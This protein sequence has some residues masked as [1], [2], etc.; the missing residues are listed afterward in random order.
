MDDGVAWG[1]EVSNA[2]PDNITVRRFRNDVSEKSFREYTKV[3]DY[4]L[5]CVLGGDIEFLNL[6]LGLMNCAS[7][8]PCYLCEIDQK[9]LKT[10]AKDMDAGSTRNS[11]RFE[12]QLENVLAH[13][14]LKK[15]KEASKDNGSVLR[16]KLLPV[17]FERVS[18]ASRT[19]HYPGY[20]EEAFRR[21]GCG[22]PKS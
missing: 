20:C 17:A 22:A 14:L 8:F 1:I 2:D 16:K 15:K 11:A 9:T 13:D 4:K 10:R 5:H 19:S 12:Q 7:T 3:V 18:R 21:I 6:V